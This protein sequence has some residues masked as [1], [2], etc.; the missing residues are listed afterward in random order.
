MPDITGVRHL[1][2]S[3]RDLDR[4]VAWY[5]D[6]LGFEVNFRES[7]PTRSAAVMH[8]PGT[9]VILGLVSFADGSGD[10]FTPTRTGLDHLCFRVP[11]REALQAW[12]RRFEEKGVTYSD[13]VETHRGPM[14]NFKDPDGI[15]LALAL[16]DA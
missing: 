13:I 15:A 9:D 10:V 4:S 5:G 16:P 3:V 1:A 12:A 7:Q 2:L 11:D 8:I 14:L 6:V